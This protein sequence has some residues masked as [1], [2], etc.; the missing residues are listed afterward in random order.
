MNDCIALIMTFFYKSYF[1]M[2]R[3]GKETKKGAFSNPKIPG[4]KNN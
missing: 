3:K 1:C 4:F 2:E